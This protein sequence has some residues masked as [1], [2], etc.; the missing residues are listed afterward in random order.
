MATKEHPHNYWNKERCTEELSKYT[1]KLEAKHGSPG[2]YN[3]AYTHGWLETIA[4][5][6]QSKTYW[7]R[8]KCFKEVREKG[9][10]NKKAFRE[11]S[12]GCYSHAVKHGFL[13]ELCNGMDVLG[14]YNLRK[15]YVFEF[16]DGYAYV[17]LTFKPSKRQW[18]HLNEKESPVYKHFHDKEQGFVFKVLSDWLRQNDAQAF[19]DKMINEYANNGWKMLN[20]KKG[21]GLGSAREWIYSL[22]ELM[23]ESEKYNYRSEF[24][25]GSPAKYAF[26][27]EH[28]LLDI[29]CA[30]MPK[31]Y[32]PAPPKWPKMRI[33]EVVEEC[34]HSRK[35]VESKYPGAYI[36]IR[37][38]DL[39]EHYFGR[40]RVSGQ[41]RTQ[42]EAVQKCSEYNSTSAL[43]KA[44]ITLYNYIMR[45]KWQDVCFK[46]MKR[47][48]NKRIAEAFTWEDILDK[49]KLCSKMK[50][51]REKYRSEYRAA[52]RKPEW[53][54]KLY[55]ML[56]IRNRKSL[57]EVQRVCLQYHTPTELKEANLYIYNYVMRMHWQEKCFS[58]MEYSHIY[59]LPFTWEEILD[60]IKLCSRLKDLTE[61]YPGEYR[62]A[63]RKTRMEEETLQSAAKQQEIK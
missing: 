10:K 11:G 21:G 8:E 4:P 6:L 15:V 28:G 37:K 45:K 13:E 5:H 22:D 59:R 31:R 3:S 17:G 52:L 29:I 34:H 19:E 20:T 7:N 50:D 26:A 46:H 16:N 42:E 2:A 9:Y 49:I 36:A 61:N 25:E 54:T 23:E 51:L 39:M 33:D 55:K 62:A 40:K 24:R 32:K 30:H 44:D 18:Q 58:H 1:R 41:R 48:K 60:K 38:M 35:L 56:P 14:N 53:R 27:Y 12:P 57:E 43:R 47:R 63:L